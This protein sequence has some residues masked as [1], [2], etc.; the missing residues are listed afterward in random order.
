M[1]IPFATFRTLGTFGQLF[2]KV[3]SVRAEE[4]VREMMSKCPYRPKTTKAV[5][6]TV[7]IVFAKI[8]PLAILER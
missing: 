3:H 1:K 7:A 6:I 2:Q 4:R 5:A 8:R